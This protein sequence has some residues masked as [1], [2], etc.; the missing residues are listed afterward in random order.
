[1]EDRINTAQVAEITGYKP[2]T[3]RRYALML[4][5]P[6]V[7][8]GN[9]KVYTWSEADIIRFKEAI[10]SPSGR[11]DRRGKPST[12]SKKTES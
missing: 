10:T 1:M 6:S 2:V 7:T 8:V 5:V 9:I 12:K 11:R 4:N 3:V